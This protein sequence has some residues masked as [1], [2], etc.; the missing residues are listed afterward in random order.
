V[1]DIDIE[2]QGMERYMDENEV[3]ERIMAQQVGGKISCKAAFDIAEAAGMPRSR[4]GE[5]LNEMDIK[6]RACQ[7]GCFN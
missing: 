7:L 3:K 5:L 4:I 6:I 2:N 1:Q